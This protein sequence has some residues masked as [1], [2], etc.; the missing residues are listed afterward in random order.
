MNNILPGFTNT[1]RLQT[2]ISDKSRKQNK[3]ITQMAV[4]TLFFTTISRRLLRRSSRSSDAEQG[5]SPSLHH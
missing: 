5:S 1:E 4:R 3:S 2:I